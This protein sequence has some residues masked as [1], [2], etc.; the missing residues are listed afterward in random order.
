M[1]QA[2]G[3]LR[4]PTDAL[5]LPEERCGPLLIAA[6]SQDQCLVS[7]RALNAVMK[8]ELPR[9]PFLLLEERHR[10]VEVSPDL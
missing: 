5:L 6:L 7:E 9:D 3:I 10:F 8:P 2:L 4:L 1:M